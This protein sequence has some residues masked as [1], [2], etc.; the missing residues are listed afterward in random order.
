MQTMMR[1]NL[2]DFHN[3]TF[4]GFDIKL[5]EESLSI[6]SEIAQQVGSPTYIRT[7]I[8]AKKEKSKRIVGNLYSIFSNNSTDGMEETKATALKNIQQKTTKWKVYNPA[9][10]VDILTFFSHLSRIIPH[11]NNPVIIRAR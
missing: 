8:F 11:K 3:I 4:N 1:Y 6:I 2:T 10:K 5:P 7:P 9:I